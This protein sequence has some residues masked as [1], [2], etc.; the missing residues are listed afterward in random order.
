MSALVNEEHEGP[1]A[2]AAP[3]WRDRIAV[4]AFLLALLLPMLLRSTIHPAP[5]PGSP[6]LLSQLHAIACLFTHKPDGWSSYY[7][8]LRDADTARWETL[9]QAELFELQPFGRRTRMHR[10]LAAWH[11]KPSRKTQHMARWILEQH[12]RAHPEQP[13]PDAIRFTRAWMIPS[14]DQP[15]AQGW[16]HPS[17]RDVP[18]QRRRVIAMYRVDELFADDAAGATQ[19]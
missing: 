8:Q 15:P 17:W 9:D 5:L 4:A 14:V 1:P 13:R 12:A 18:P 6:A 16:R 3:R 10:L 11:A 19:P 2:G 7:V